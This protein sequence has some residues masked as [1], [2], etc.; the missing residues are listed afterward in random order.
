MF[1][2]SSTPTYAIRLEC[3]LHRSDLT[4]CAVPNILVLGKACVLYVGCSRS[5]NVHAVERLLL[6]PAVEVASR[7]NT[8]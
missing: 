5:W 1:G 3:R 7:T 8:S 2:L 6:L 4:C